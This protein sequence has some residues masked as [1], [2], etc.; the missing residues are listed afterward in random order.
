MLGYSNKMKPSNRALCVSVLVHCPPNC[1]F[2]SNQTHTLEPETGP[3]KCKLWLWCIL[4][5]TLYVWLFSG[6]NVSM[7]WQL[8]KD[9]FWF[10][11]FWNWQMTPPQSHQ[12]GFQKGSQ[13]QM[14][15]V[16]RPIHVLNTKSKG[17]SVNT[18]LLSPHFKIFT[19]FMY[20]QGYVPHANLQKYRNRQ[21]MAGTGS[22]FIRSLIWDTVYICTF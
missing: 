6:L 22:S 18:I 21:H 3:Q 4:A 15:D 17:Y 1:P 9:S 10:W 19:L 14:M 11:G 16:T 5:E 12:R 7:K 8:Y 20:V 2:Y 13:A